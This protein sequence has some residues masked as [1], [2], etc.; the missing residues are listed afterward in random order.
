MFDIL[1][2]EDDFKLNRIYCSALQDADFHTFAAYNGEEAMELIAE[3][4]MDLVIS[5]IMMP[6][7]DGY[8]LTKQLRKE[9]PEMPILMIS[10][11]EGY[12]DKRDGFLAGIDDYMVKPVDLNEMLLRVQALLRRAKI[13]TDRKLTV[14]NTVL[15]YDSYSAEFDG[16]T[17]EIPQKEFLVLYKLM[18][19]PGRTFTRRQLMDEFWGWESDS[20]ER[21]V[22]VHINRL[23]ERLR[24]CRDLRIDTV[25]GLGY[26]GVKLCD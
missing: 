14:G 9:Y 19:Y 24:D 25:R 26:R 18:S 13:V 23:R 12:A 1:V 21:T 11:K 16:K 20:E 4:P 2:A 8:T 7:M 17:V 15:R 10:A 3:H 6:G 5:D 22:D